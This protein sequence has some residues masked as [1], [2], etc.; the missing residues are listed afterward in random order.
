MD[1]LDDMIM[2]YDN[3]QKYKRNG[4]SEMMKWINIRWFWG[5]FAIRASKSRKSL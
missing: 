1:G 4:E 3:R 2:F 5:G